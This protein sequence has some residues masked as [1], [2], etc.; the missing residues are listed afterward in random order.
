MYLFLRK[1]TQNVKIW[2]YFLLQ[3][4]PHG[5]IFPL[6]ILLLLKPNLKNHT[7]SEIL[8]VTRILFQLIFNSCINFLVPFG[9]ISV[10]STFTCRNGISYT[11]LQTNSVNLFEIT[12]YFLV[13]PKHVHYSFATTSL[14]FQWKSPFYEK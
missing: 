6:K 9:Y 3:N 5:E 10:K 8:N 13:K 11:F 1:I 14:Q 4:I 2:Y 7:S 12:T